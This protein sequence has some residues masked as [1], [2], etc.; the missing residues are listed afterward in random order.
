MND[1]MKCATRSIRVLVVGLMAVSLAAV[2]FFPQLPAGRGQSG[3]PHKC[4]CGMCD[5]KCCGMACCKMARDKTPAVPPPRTGSDFKPLVLASWNA[6]ATDS[7]AGIVAG[8]HRASELAHGLSLP[9][10]QA[11]HVRIQT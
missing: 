2:A 11:E 6:P 4:C 5:G 8:I 10:L 1:A 3:A 9:T 7:P